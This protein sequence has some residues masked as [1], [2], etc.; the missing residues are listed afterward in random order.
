MVKG[1]KEQKVVTTMTFGFK[2]KKTKNL[3]LDQ[4]VSQ[5]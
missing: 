4:Q 3:N 5:S 2:L 1:E